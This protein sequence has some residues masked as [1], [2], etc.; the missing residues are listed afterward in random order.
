MH[1]IRKGLALPITG[2]PRQQIETVA[3]PR[4]VGVVA[5]DY[6]GLKPTMHVTVGDD[7]RRGQLL[8]ED[9]KLPGV[10]HTA[11]AEGR[12]LAVNR[13]DRRALQSVVIELSRGER[14]GHPDTTAF[15]AF[16]GRHPSGLTGDE[17]RALLVESGL[18]A[19][20][21]GRPFSKVANPDDR[22]HSIFVT[23]TDT[24]PLAASV[25]AV[26]MG[27]E[28]AFDDGLF[29]LSRLTDGPLFVCTP[30][31]STLRLPE[32]ERLRHEE[33]SGPHPA[34]TVGLHIHRLD[35]VDRHKV[36]WHVGYQ[37]VIAIGR[38]FERGE[39]SA[40]RVIALGGPSVRNPRLLRTRLG[41]SLDDL[42]R[43]E[44]QAPD[45]EHRVI[46]GSVLSGRAA[47]GEVFGYLGRYHAQVSVLA[48]GR[49]REF[50]G[51]LGAGFDK[52]STVNTFA[53]RLLPGRR[54]AFTT[55]ANGS[56][57]AIIPLGMYERVMPMDLLPTFLARALVMRD[58]EKAEELGCLELDE[59][60]LA[61]CSFVCPG[62]TDFGPP[63]R[64]VLTE[65][66]KEG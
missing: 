21:R 38:L 62:K 42:V 20:L 6:V 15:S 4:R 5:A 46:S 27:A 13:G 52:Y 29:A 41:A 47:A 24:N 25:E 14:E 63:L 58:I 55:S 40:E 44:L 8:M 61:L 3:P 50:L 53:S 66:E 1:A 23:A 48:E 7:I 43:D 45:A 19:A 18:W 16:S 30:A 39:F 34:G 51:W 17:V 22:P 11:P 31:G 33:F 56:P 26:M 12:V 36:V 28:G 49:A 59:E 32:I 35:P 10:R 2:A 37:D 60:D 57:R 54:F 64:E 9:K 65:I